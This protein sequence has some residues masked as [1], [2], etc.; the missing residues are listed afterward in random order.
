[1]KAKNHVNV[2]RVVMA[3]LV[4]PLATPTVFL[5]YQILLAGDKKMPV[6]T[7]IGIY[8]TYGPYSYLVALLLG[9]PIL[10]L[11]HRA[12][13]RKLVYFIVGGT[14]LGLVPALA[15]GFIGIGQTSIYTLCLVSGLLSA[16]AFWLLS[17]W[18]NVGAA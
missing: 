5:L 10:Y 4:A 11:F 6:D 16:V 12:N 3:L 1:M 2:A 15:I 18:G 8:L 17:G 7:V 13:L 9:A 14:T